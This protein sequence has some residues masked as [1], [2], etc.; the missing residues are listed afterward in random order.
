MVAVPSPHSTSGEGYLI[1]TLAAHTVREH[2]DRSISVLPGD[3][4]SNSILISNQ[5]GSWH[6]FIYAGVFEEC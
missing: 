3:G 1:G 5:R 6:G 4:S 2:E